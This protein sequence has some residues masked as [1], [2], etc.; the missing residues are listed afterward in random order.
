MDDTDQMFVV[1]LLTS[2]TETV[3][4]NCGP[5]TDISSGGDKILFEQL[6]APNHV[7]MID[8][9]R[10]SNPPPGPDGANGPPPFCGAVLTRRPLGGIQRL[11]RQNPN[12]KVFISPIRDGHGLPEAE[13]ISVTDGLQ[14]DENVA[15]SPD[16]DLLYFLSER[17]GRLCIW[18][19]R[20]SRHEAAG[21]VSFCRPALS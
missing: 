1:N 3:G 18:A 10:G 5:P 20:S 16:G 4:V 17:D 15:W 9:P 2:T 13:W 6:R 12:K 21:W 7:M 11:L 19:Q 8:V 14:V